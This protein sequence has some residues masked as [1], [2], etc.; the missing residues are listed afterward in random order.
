MLRSSWNM[1]VSPKSNDKYPSKRHTEERQTGEEEQC[2]HAD[3][4][5]RDAAD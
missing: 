3:R 1:Q 2:D 4:D 5:W